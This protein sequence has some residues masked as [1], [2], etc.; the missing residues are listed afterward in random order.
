MCK[1][2]KAILQDFPAVS[3]SDKDVEVVQFHS[4]AVTTAWNVPIQHTHTQ[5]YTFRLASGS[6]EAELHGSGRKE[7]SEEEKSESDRGSGW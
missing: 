6:W 2:K 4:S 3:S 1:L 7:Q 5:V